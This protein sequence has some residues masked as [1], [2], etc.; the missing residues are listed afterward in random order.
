MV[1]SREEFLKQITD[2]KKSHKLPPCNDET[3]PV[4]GPDTESQKQLVDLPR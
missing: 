4:P 2:L 1:K 3:A